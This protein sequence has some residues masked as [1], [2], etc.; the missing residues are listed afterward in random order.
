MS[1]QAESSSSQIDVPSI[2]NIPSL[3]LIPVEQSEESSKHLG[4]GRWLELDEIEYIV[5]HTNEKKGWEV[6]R[7]KKRSKPTSDAVDGN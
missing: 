1:T 3:K 5:P 6:C 4:H 2:I 7:R